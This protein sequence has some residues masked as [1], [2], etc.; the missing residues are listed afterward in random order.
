DRAGGPAPPPHPGEAPPLR[1]GA[2]RRL[3]QPAAEGRAVP[4]GGIAAGDARRVA[5]R[6]GRGGAAGDAAGAGRAGEPGRVAAAAAGGH[7]ADPV[8]EG[9]TPGRADEVPR[10][11][12]RVGE[13][14]DAVPARIAPAA[15]GGD[16]GDGVNHGRGPT[17]GS[18]S[19]D[20][21]GGSAGGPG[22]TGTLLGRSAWLGATRS[23]NPA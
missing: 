22:L 16:P 6:G 19:P 23:R 9:E 13:A 21:G 20:G 1:D 2:V 11:A 3:L 7:R 12:G 14:D 10:L 15:A 4:G 5:G 8:G 18:R 17:G